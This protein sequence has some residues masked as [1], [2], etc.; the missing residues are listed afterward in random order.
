M[1]SRSDG[2][3]QVKTKIVQLVCPRALLLLFL[4][5]P[6]PASPGPASVRS[7]AFAGNN[8]ITYVAISDSVTN[9]GNKAFKDCANLNTVAMSKSVKV[10][11]AEA[12]AN[13]ALTDVILP[14]SLESLGRSSFAGAPV[15]SMTLPFVGGS[16]I[17]SNPFIGYLFGALSYSGNEAYVPETLTSVTIS[18]SAGKVPAYAFYGVKSLISVTVKSGVISIGNSAFAECSLLADVYIPATVT[19]IAADANVFNSPFYN[20][21]EKLMLVMEVT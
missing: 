17:T 9:I 12:F 15:Q 16:R 1:L 2:I 6:L 21:S 10:I 11:G 3:S 19:E 14:D 13:T 20:T 8:D 18:G 4:C 7:S 5:S